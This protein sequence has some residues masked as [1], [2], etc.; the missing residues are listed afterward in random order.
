VNRNFSGPTLDGWCFGGALGIP[1]TGMLLGFWG[2]PKLVL[3]IM[4]VAVGAMLF[5]FFTTLP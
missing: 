3:A 5:W 2:R 4:P 1:I